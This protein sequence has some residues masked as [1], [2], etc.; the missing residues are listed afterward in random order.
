[1]GKLLADLCSQQPRK[2]VFKELDYFLCTF[3]SLICKQNVLVSQKLEEF[4]VLSGCSACGSTSGFVR[5]RFMGEWVSNPFAWLFAKMVCSDTVTSFLIGKRWWLKKNPFTPSI[6]NPVQANRNSIFFTGNYLYVD[7]CFQLLLE[8]SL[9]CSNNRAHFKNPG[10]LI[11]SSFGQWQK[12][13]LLLIKQII[14][15]NLSRIYHLNFYKLFPGNTQ[16]DWRCHRTNKLACYSSGSYEDITHKLFMTVGLVAVNWKHPALFWCLTDILLL[17]YTEII[18]ALG[19]LQYKKELKEED[20]EKQ[21][22]Q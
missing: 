5:S 4:H 15:A 2:G 18:L 16:R 20:L 13:C 19:S 9:A 22:V 12:C 11:I 7:L 1:M 21:L 3:R 8:A 10:N 17:L 6:K 14:V